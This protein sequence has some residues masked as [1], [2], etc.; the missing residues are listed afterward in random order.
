M[1]TH[2]EVPRPFALS[3]IALII[4]CL[5]IVIFSPRAEAQSLRKMTGKEYHDKLQKQ[6]SWEN[7]RCNRLKQAKAYAKANRKQSKE[8]IRNEKINSRIR[9][10]YAT[11]SK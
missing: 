8:A 11:S 10:I 2:Q 3:V 9:R 1:K 6:N 5:L 4:V 7:Y